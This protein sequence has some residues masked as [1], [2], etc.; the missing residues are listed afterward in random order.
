MTQLVSKQGETRTQRLEMFAHAL[1]FVLGFGVIFTLLGTTA[2]LLGGTLLRYQMVIQQIGGVLLIIFGLTMMGLFFKLSEWLGRNKPAPR[3]FSGILLKLC[4][5]F[6]A[7][8]YTERRVKQ[9]EDVNRG[10]GYLSSF[11]VGVSFSAGW[12]PCIGPILASILL[13]AG[14]SA[15]ASQGAFLLAVY[16]AGLGIPFLLT[17]LAFG[18]MTH[19]LRKL[20]RY[21]GIV[22]Y[23]SGGFLILMGY[24]L[25]TNQLTLLVEQFWFLN[26]I[27]FTLE[28]TISNALGFGSIDPT[29]VNALQA[30]PIALLAGMISFISPCVL[31]LV[32]AY[33]SYLGG[34]SLNHA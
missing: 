8:L 10:Y 21:L 7:L 17:A 31:P 28:G 2:G 32:P 27:V 14:N 6:N 5:F 18:R 30:A 26:E 13:L 16:S 34:T 23:I 33:I 1:A 24:F 11:T 20:N 22:S 19:L 9:V 3:S 15:T 4:N 25:W 12:V 29:A